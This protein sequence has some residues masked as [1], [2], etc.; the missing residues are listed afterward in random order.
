MQF[1]SQVSQETLQ[2]MI[3]VGEKL[4]LC[5]FLEE[6]YKK[7]GKEGVYFETILGTSNPQ[8]V[9]GGIGG[10]EEYDS[11]YSERFDFNF[12][13][14]QIERKKKLDLGN[15]QS[16]HDYNFAFE[17]KETYSNLLKKAQEISAESFLAWINDLDQILKAFQ[18][19][20]SSL[21]DS[22]KSLRHAD[23]K[24]E[25]STVENRVINIPKNQVRGFSNLLNELKELAEKEDFAFYINKREPWEKYGKKGVKSYQSF[26]VLVS[27]L[28]TFEGTDKENSQLVCRN[29]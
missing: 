20:E 7:T 5:P 14:Y 6:N 27:Y 29:G 28:K 22:T 23:F 3:K 11:K 1:A 15:F 9:K 21:S 18:K 24:L 19:K 13:L 26:Q 12:D 25:T 4:R 17:N 8:K 16:K 2:T 10:L